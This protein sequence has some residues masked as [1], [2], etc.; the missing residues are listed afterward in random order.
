[1]SKP[2]QFHLLL[3]ETTRLQSM[4]RKSISLSKDCECW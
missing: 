3:G 1:M 2:I 4:G